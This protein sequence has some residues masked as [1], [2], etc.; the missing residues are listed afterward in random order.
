MR[1]HTR[2]QRLLFKGPT[3]EK[4]TEIDFQMNA[5]QLYPI[6]KPAIIVGMCAETGL[7]TSFVEHAIVGRLSFN[8]ERQLK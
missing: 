4:K 1:G 2:A 6:V 8:R 3:S 7:V 5:N